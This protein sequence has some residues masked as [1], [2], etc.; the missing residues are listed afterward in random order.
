[1]TTD[2][3]SEVISEN[4][5]SSSYVD[6]Y[7]NASLPCC[8]LN[9][10]S[11]VDWN[12]KD[13]IVGS[14]GSVKQFE[15]NI[16]R[17]Y[18]YVPAKYFP[19]GKLCVN[20]AALFQSKAMFGRD[21]GIRYYG[22]ITETKLLK[23]KDIHFPLRKNN[24]DEMYYAFNI[25]SWEKLSV[26]IDVQYDT[27]REP[28]LTNIFLLEHCS[29]AYELFCI[30]SSAKYI[31]FRELNQ[32][33]GNAINAANPHFEAVKKFGNGKGIWIHNGYIDVFDKDGERLFQSPP[34]ISDFAADPKNI[35][36]ILTDMIVGN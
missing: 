33:I 23:R 13:V 15:D 16:A 24:G 30:D 5:D 8:I 32:L 21:C 6:F 18:Y 31:C 3:I 9:K 12:T 20:Y 22:R 26:P 1:M 10:L 25:S 29:K 34:R 4:C 17:N 36:C 14:F 35:L 11:K 7:N 2:N 27:D 28:Q 19:E